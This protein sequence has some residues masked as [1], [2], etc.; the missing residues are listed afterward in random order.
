[1]ACLQTK[2]GQ[3]VRKGHEHKS[4]S[5]SRVRVDLP[6]HVAMLLKTKAVDDFSDTDRNL[7]TKI[8]STQSIL[9]LN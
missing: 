5:C 2:L 3:T 9:Q 6:S 8:P 7:T 4:G 1:M